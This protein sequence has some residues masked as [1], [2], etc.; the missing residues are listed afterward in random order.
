MVAAQKIQIDSVINRWDILSRIHPDREAQDTIRTL[1]GS[2][3]KRK[4][5][6]VILLSLPSPSPLYKNC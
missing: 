6:Q 2:Q 3:V 1:G 5:G 4:Y